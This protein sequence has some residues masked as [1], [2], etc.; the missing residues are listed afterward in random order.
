MLNDQRVEQ[1]LFGC[2]YMTLQTSTDIFRLQFSNQ[3]HAGLLRK[4][5]KNPGLQC[6]EAIAAAHLSSG[7]VTEKGTE[8]QGFLDT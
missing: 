2:P 6:G 4:T 1:I 7:T 3:S 8:R 5:L